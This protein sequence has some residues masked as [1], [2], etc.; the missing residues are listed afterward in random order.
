MTSDTKET[1]D[2]YAMHLE[3]AKQEEKAESLFLAA[4]KQGEF[5]RGDVWCEVAK[6]LW[7]ARQ[8]LMKLMTKE[9]KEKTRRTV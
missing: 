5:Y 6:N 9:E 2:A 1:T 7:E 4:V 3:L 8:T